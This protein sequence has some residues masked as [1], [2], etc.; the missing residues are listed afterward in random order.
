MTRPRVDGE[1]GLCD[2]RIFDE[3]VLQRINVGGGVWR[4][5]GRPRI[6]GIDSLIPFVVDGVGR[7]VDSPK[8]YGHTHSL[9]RLRHFRV[10]RQFWQ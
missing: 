8:L 4:I 6:T 3:K 9:R 5:I 1:L 10:L 2:L 7:G